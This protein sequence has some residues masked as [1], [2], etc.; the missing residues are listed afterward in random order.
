VEISVLIIHF[1]VGKLPVDVLCVGGSE[2]PSSGLVLCPVFRRRGAHLLTEAPTEVSRGGKAAPPADGGDGVLRGDQ[3]AT[4]L[5]N[6]QMEQIGR[7]RAADL[8]IEHPTEIGGRD[9]GVFRDV[10]KLK[11]AGEVC[12]QTDLGLF[13]A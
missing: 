2:A 8:E 11:V 1:F 10:R 7:K 6:A 4:R 9:T 13:L 3:C 12:V 5:F